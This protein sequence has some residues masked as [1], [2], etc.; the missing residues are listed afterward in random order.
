MDHLIEGAV[1]GVLVGLA[2]WGIREVARWR[3]GR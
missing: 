3:R 2:W 1:L